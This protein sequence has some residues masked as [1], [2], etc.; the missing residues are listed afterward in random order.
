MR[1][2]QFWKKVKLIL[3]G[4]GYTQKQAAMACGVSLGTFYGWIAK[5]ILP[6]VENS[7]F[8]ARFLGVNVEY[9]VTGK[10]PDAADRIQKLSAI[11][12]KAETELME[13]RRLCGLA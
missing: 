6:P 2:E 3:K 1:E 8:L 12:K 10:K 11:L 13:L 4:R 7:V 9:L 5:G